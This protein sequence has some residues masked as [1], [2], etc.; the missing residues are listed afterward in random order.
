MVKVD[1][2]KRLVELSWY[3]LESKAK[4]YGVVGG[5]IDSDEVYDGFEAE[6]RQLCEE[7]NIKPTAADM[8]GFDESRPSCQLVLAKLS[9]QKK[10]RKSKKKS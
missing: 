4:Y 8:V 10:K 6:Y 2:K 7:L 5:K 3:I 1:K 9:S